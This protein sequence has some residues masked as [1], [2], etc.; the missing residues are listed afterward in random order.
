MIFN[1]KG[2]EREKNLFSGNIEN[3]NNK[4]PDQEKEAESIKNL[5]FGI[6]VDRLKTGDLLP[7]G[8][9]TFDS[10]LEK[11]LDLDFSLFDQDLEIFQKSREKDFDKFRDDLSKSLES[12][13]I[14]IDPYLFFVCQSVQ[15][16]VA[17]SLEPKDWGFEDNFSSESSES[18]EELY[19]KEKPP[20]LSEIGQKSQCAEIAALGQYIL[21]KFELKSSYMSGVSKV[22]GFL[23]YHSFLVIEDPRDEK[24]TL[25]FDI[26]R[27]TIY[28]D[29]ARKIFGANILKSEIPLSSELFKDKNDLLITATNATTR[30][31]ESAEYG[32]QQIDPGDV[33]T[34]AAES[35]RLYKK[36]K[37]K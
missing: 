27:P 12:D 21:Q 15:R 33:A 19:R 20:R 9:S 17:E 31:G 11:R 29:G 25:V 28:K 30:K 10:K 1:H 8:G 35:G 23:E 2:M 7:V 16:K 13:N 5:N 26:A 3:E 34:Q 36:F 37:E 24:S 18:R 6:W 22:K 14:D 4:S 32:V